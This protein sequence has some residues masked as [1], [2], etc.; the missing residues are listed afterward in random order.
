MSQGYNNNRCSGYALASIIVEIFSRNNFRIK[1]NAK[2]KDLGMYFYDG[3][4]ICQEKLLRGC[5][6]ES[7]SMQ[8][9]NEVVSKLWHNLFYAQ[10]PDFRKPGLCYYPKFLYL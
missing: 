6:P 3:L 2:K 7:A 8:F 4:S 9:L 5:I 1:C 10:S